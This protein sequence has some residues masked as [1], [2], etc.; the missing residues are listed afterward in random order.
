[1]AGVNNSPTEVRR[2]NVEKLKKY[3]D[4]TD[5]LPSQKNGRVSKVAIAKAAGVPLRS[6]HMNP[7]CAH[8]IEE[9]VA[10]KGVKG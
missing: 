6:L 2:E 9:F 10:K 1:M 8:L 3:L 4:S 5:Q 7:A